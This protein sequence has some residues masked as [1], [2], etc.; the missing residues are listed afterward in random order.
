M[1]R[2]LA[3][4]ADTVTGRKF[5]R[6]TLTKTFWLGFGYCIIASAPVQPVVVVSQKVPRFNYSLYFC[7]AGASFFQMDKVLFS[8]CFSLQKARSKTLHG[9]SVGHDFATTKRPAASFGIGENL[10]SVV[11]E[12]CVDL[13]DTEASVPGQARL[14]STGR[15]K[16][17]GHT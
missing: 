2:K 14:C 11:I 5:V 12:V 3:S 10:I 17:E 4:S 1:T 6:R 16:G 15:G 7:G 13:R 9:R 8:V